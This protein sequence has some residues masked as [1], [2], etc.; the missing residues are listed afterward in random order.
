MITKRS[1]Q[2]VYQIIYQNFFF[3]FY[4]YF[5]IESSNW[6]WKS[7]SN[8]YNMDIQIRVYLKKLCI[9]V[10][11]WIFTKLYLFD[12]FKGQI[13]PIGMSDVVLKQFF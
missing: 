10:S 12:N 4:F 3:Y 1:Y 13:T 9:K 7:L 6:C 5:L 8:G 2:N 11:Y